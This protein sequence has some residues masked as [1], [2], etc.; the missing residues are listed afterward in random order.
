MTN[1]HPGA[2]TTTSRTAPTEAAAHQT[3]PFVPNPNPPASASTVIGFIIA[4]ALVFG[5]FYMMGMAFSVPGAEIWLFAGGIM[6]DAVGLWIAFG[7][8]PYLADRKLD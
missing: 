7:L 4:A 6:V 3:S 5:G 8:I 2:Q 1:Q